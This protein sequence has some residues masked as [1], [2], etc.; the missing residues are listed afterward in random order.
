MP[1]AFAWFQVSK[2]GLV[3]RVDG[4]EAHAVGW[5]DIG[6]TSFL[7]PT[8]GAAATIIT[9]DRVVS[10]AATTDAAG[11]AAL[12]ALA[13]RARRPPTPPRAPTTT[14]VAGRGRTHAT[15]ALL[16]VRTATDSTF[17]AL[18]GDGH[19]VVRERDALWY[20]T[21]DRFTYKP[22]E[23]AYVKGWVRWTT[24]GVNPDVELPAAGDV[25]AWAL[26]D[27][28]GTKL[29]S[30]TAPLTDQGGFDL[31]VAL[32]ANANLGTA[33]LVLTTHGQRH[34]V[35]LEIEEFRAPA[36]A[37]DLVDDVTH[38][39]A[40]PLIL[41]ERVEMRAEA[42]YYAGGGLP[43]AEIRWAATLV[44]TRYQPP[45]WD[46]FAF[47]PPAARGARRA[48]P[49]AVDVTQDG[50]L[51]GGST[52]GAIFGV[53]ALSVRVARG[54]PRRRHGVRR[55]PH[56]DPRELAADPRPPRARTTWA[57][58]CSPTTTDQ[59]EV[60]ATDIDGAPVAGVPIAV[61]VEGVLGSER[62]RADARVVEHQHCAVTS[63]T[64]PVRCAW[65]RSNLLHAYTATAR[66]VDPRGRAS[67]TQYAI[68]WASIA[69]D[70]PLRLTPDRAAYKAG[71]VRARRAGVRC[72]A[73]DRDR[74][75]RAQRRD[76]AAAAGAHAARDDDRRADRARLHRGR[77]RGRRPH[78]DA[79]PERRRQRRAAARVDE[80]VGRA[81][82]L[83]RD[84]AARDDHARDAEDPRARRAG[85]VRG[86]GPARGRA[87]RERGGRADRGRRGDPRAVG[88]AA[89]RSAAAVLPAGRRRHGGRVDARR[90]RRRGAGPRGGARRDPRRAR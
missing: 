30:G 29:A 14:S 79:A 8:A 65:R 61:D 56:G 40:A 39:G 28:R 88:A 16:A 4:D 11:H 21:D 32:P 49:P 52:A 53:T 69:R 83:D 54:A 17:A 57:S 33:Q 75:L 15:T 74:E 46:E 58:G 67:A 24:T 59:L 47:V 51:G 64:A 38:A 76:G 82:G 34:E 20:A 48:S 23:T 90:G 26:S 9:D 10:A 18:T 1:R 63:A 45:G 85:D 13:R 66:V 55:R 73:G 6:P 22:G 71:D 3:G 60:V 7:A 62:E 70:E 41:G 78:R 44:P 31:A 42:K 89:R 86:D 81:A 87:G 2:L 25:I 19:Q 77:A 43:D 12:G 37:V 50:T 5:R 35:P 80:R 27:A 36:F 72:R 68:P 84:R